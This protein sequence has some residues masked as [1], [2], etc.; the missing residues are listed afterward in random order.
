VEYGTKLPLD[1]FGPTTALLELP[2]AP[3]PALL[4]PAVS[5]VGLEPW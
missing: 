1:R 5:E 3:V 4:A 2:P